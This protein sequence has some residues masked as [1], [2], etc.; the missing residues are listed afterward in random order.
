MIFFEAIVAT[1]IQW[2]KNNWRMLFEISVAVAGILFVAHLASNAIERKVAARTAKQVA[3]ATNA[4]QVETNKSHLRE[5]EL[6]RK[7]ESSDSLIASLKKELEH[8]PVVVFSK[9]RT[10]AHLH[11]QTDAVVSKCSDNDAVPVLSTVAVR[12]LDSARLNTDLGATSGSDAEV[13]TPSDVTVSEFVENDLEVVRLYQRLA[14]RHD[15]LV[16][17]VEGK[18]NT[19]LDSSLK[20]K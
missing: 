13:G 15:E 11:T 17:Y 6:I 8:D 7:I 12:V 3:L 18:L 9:S 19:S 20:S 1:L 16:N 2:V 5:T 14:A 4:L 10:P